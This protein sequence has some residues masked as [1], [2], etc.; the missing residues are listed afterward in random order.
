MS[1]QIKAAPP[2][3]QL[4]WTA[5]IVLLIAYSAAAQAPASESA[6][7]R[8]VNYAGVAK[9][10]D[11]KPFKGIIGAT[12]AVYA[13]QEGGAP[14][15]METQNINASANGSFAV[16]LGATKPAGLPQDVFSSG[17]ARWLGIRYN[18]G[19]EQPRV[20][21][22]SVPYALKAG[23]A[24]TLGGLPPSAFVLA[25]PVSKANPAVNASD[26]VA[27]PAGAITGSGTLGFLPDFTGA[28]TIG[29]SAIFQTGVSPSAK[30]GINTTAP[31]AALD[32]HGGAAVRGTLALP[33]TGTATSAAGKNSQPQNLAAS[34]FNSGTSA[35]I[36]QT[37]QW[38]AEPVGNN[39]A[40]ASGSLNL[41][42]GQGTA[43]PAE[44]GLSIASNG[45]LT[46]AAGQGFPGAGTITGVTTAAGSGL[47][48][49]GSSGSLALG[50][51]K[52]CATNQVLHWSGT[53]WT[54][55]TPG[56]GTITGVTAGTDLTGGGTTGV[57]TLNLNT[58]N[59]DK[60]YA[61][62]GAANFFTGQGAFSGS[63]NVTPLEAF[64]N[65]TADV[66]SAIAGVMY[67]G[68]TGSAAVQ[69]QALA[70]S[71]EV[72]GV[73]GYVQSGGAV[74][75]YGV[76]GAQSKTA[77]YG[78]F[79]GA[80]VWGDAG[81]LSSIGVSGTADEGYGVA[82]F[83]NSLT[84]GA[85][86]GVNRATSSIAPGLEGATYSPVGIGVVGYGNTSSENFAGNSG[87]NPVGVVGDS[88]AASGIGVWG[89]TD[90]GTSVYGS[91]YSGTGVYGLSSTG[92]GVTGSSTT[93]SGVVGTSSGGGIA[94]VYGVT[95]N[96]SSDAAYAVWGDDPTTVGANGGVYGYS[97]SGQ[98]VYGVS[99]S[100]SAFH[101]AGYFYA[102]N[103]ALPLVGI[104]PSG[105]CI[106]YG[107][108]DLICTGSKSAAVPLSNHRWARLYAV[109]SPEN[110]FE[111]FGS[112]TLSNGSTFVPLEAN[113]RDTVT[114]S[115]DYHV[116]LTP[117]GECEG[118]YIASTST[119]GFEVRELHHGTSGVAFDYRIVVRRKGYEN[120]RMQDVTEVQEHLLAQRQEAAKRPMHRP[121]VGPPMANHTKADVRMPRLEQILPSHGERLT[122]VPVVRQPSK[123]TK[124]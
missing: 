106:V 59:T 8:L 54:C 86:G 40:S 80:G 99:D 51:I 48:G 61:Q 41:L 107:D 9:D 73:E 32:I 16:M 67:S 66:V 83:N 116:F 31:T 84:Q 55:S 37:F 56:S 113:F 109:E 45:Q 14:L 72:F 38:K 93:S 70:K 108:G 120:I 22:L 90:T 18:G 63:S 57:V 12:F 111:D 65:D 4:A 46:F 97:F 98:G 23:D 104:G 105:N 49:G 68:Q 20:A 89:S 21:L 115:Q 79:S 50:L 117:R 75:V 29:N 6:V 34:A 27:P 74:G 5:L 7:P 60:R 1:P 100:T 96:T 92:A 102:P 124:P 33:A 44:T 77:A 15:W 91:T 2:N 26:S 24:Q 76:D 30:I 64:Q 103:G 13:E 11:G 28:A 101:E 123:N 52:S 62:L 69:G 35:A 53:A 88:G 78:V 82:G 71:G 119:T 122:I 47:T 10:A 42:F 94:G 19:A 36:A 58:T 114:S 17:Q 81:S 25:A 87:F 110:W 118:L 39:T 95:N 43:A 3:R 112:A 121:A 85:I